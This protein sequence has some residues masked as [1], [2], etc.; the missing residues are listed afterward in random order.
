MGSNTTM[1]PNGAYQCVYPYSYIAEWQV[2]GA[3]CSTDPN[4][5]PFG[6]SAWNEAGG[7]LR[8]ADTGD[9]YAPDRGRFTKPVKYVPV[10]RRKGEETYPTLIISIQLCG[11]Q[12]T[13]HKQVKNWAGSSVEVE[14]FNV[15]GQTPGAPERKMTLSQKGKL[16]ATL[17]C[18]IEV[19]P[20]DVKGWLADSKPLH[21]LVNE[22]LLDFKFKLTGVM[23]GGKPVAGQSHN[24]VFLYCRKTIVFLPGLFGSELRFRQR[25]GTVIGYPAF[26][27]SGH[28]EWKLLNANQTIGL[29][30]CDENGVPLFSFPDIS[31]L[32]LHGIS[33]TGE[34]VI[35]PFYVCHEARMKMLPF[36]P[37]NFL[38]YTLVIYPYDWRS[39]L[40]DAAARLNQRL[41]ELQTKKLTPAPDTD[42]QVAVMGHST[43][44]VVIR[45]ALGAITDDD[46]IDPALKTGN[47]PKAEDLISLAFF[48][49]VP[50]NGAVKALPVLMTGLQEPK[51]N[52]GYLDRM[53]PFLVPESLVAVSLVMPIVYH[54]ATTKDYRYRPA[55]SP[56]RP[57]GAG[58]D[59]EADKSAFVKAALD[60]G[61]MP[62]PWPVKKSVTNYDDRQNL[63]QGADEWH[64]L[65]AELAWRTNGLNL[66]NETAGGWSDVY[67]FEAEIKRRNLQFQHD[68]RNPPSGWNTTLAWRANAFHEKSKTAITGVWKQRTAI[69]FGI[70]EAPTFRQ[71]NLSKGKDIKHSGGVLGVLH[72]KRVIVMDVPSVSKPGFQTVDWHNGDKSVQFSGGI[73][74][75]SQ[76]RMNGDQVTET[77]WTLEWVTQSFGGDGTVPSDSQLA[78]ADNV[79]KLIPIADYAKSP[80]HM[81]TTK[82]AHVWESLVVS[83][84]RGF[85]GVKDGSGKNSAEQQ[86]DAA[87]AQLK[88]PSAHDSNKDP[89][90]VKG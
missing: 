26:W 11:P 36:V 39:D 74:N 49:S 75:F 88:Q 9:G 47:H 55:S 90:F 17:S 6:P 53:I 71:I 66:L 13:G 78:E 46:C 83:M 48:L 3:E 73:D 82:V 65:V 76:Y 84:H 18:E 21:A 64:K 67:W 1:T 28:R 80:K 86:K 72:D 58:I 15:A 40:T 57:P 51:Q 60:A 16:S 89:K 35:N 54:L 10:K 85:S 44:G 4:A 14:L 19:K 27:R 77:P 23:D 87:L 30:E 2:R 68:N 32:M 52:P 12:L 61:L 20:S 45:R 62:R 25:D 79:A 22:N 31:L 38:L 5:V 7:I 37:E 33:W 56:D 43:G 8:P 81:E 70:A 29:L 50:F 59:P 41:L 63:A 69:F 34:D 24:R 42:D